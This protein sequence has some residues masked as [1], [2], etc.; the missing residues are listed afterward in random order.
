[1]GVEE[2]CFHR[3]ICFETMNP[4]LFKDER[5]AGSSGPLPATRKMEV[6]LKPSAAAM[7]MAVWLAGFAPHRTVGTN[8][9]ITVYLPAEE[10]QHV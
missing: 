4:H 6:I 1:M 7:K 5:A 2:D 3:I 10:E 8:P 9:A